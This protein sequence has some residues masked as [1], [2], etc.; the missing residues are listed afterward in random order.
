MGGENVLSGDEGQVHELGR[1]GQSQG[2][3]WWPQCGQHTARL[4]GGGWVLADKAASS[5]DSLGAS[6]LGEHQP[7]EGAVCGTWGERT[8]ESG[9]GVGRGTWQTG[10]RIQ[11]EQGGCPEEPLQE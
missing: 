5:W 9:R 6:V 4:A 2:R 7:A 1:E 11:T 8:Q 3:A 10:L